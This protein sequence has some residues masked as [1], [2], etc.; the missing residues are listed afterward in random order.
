MATDVRITHAREFLRVTAQGVYDLEQTK[1]ALLQANLNYQKDLNEVA[2]I[3]AQKFAGRDKEIGDGLGSLGT[4]RDVNRV[5]AGIVG[6]AVDRRVRVRTYL[7]LVCHLSQNLLVG[8][9]QVDPIGVKAHRPAGCGI[10]GERAY[11]RRVIEV[12]PQ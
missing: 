5:C 1:D 4:Q 6:V 9:S 3:V 11:V 2:A 8:R 7:E 12:R 10:N